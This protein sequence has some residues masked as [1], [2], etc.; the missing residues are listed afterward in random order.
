MATTLLLRSMKMTSIGNFIPTVCTALPGTSHS[1]SSG[2]SRFLR[3]RPRRRVRK[4]SA[5]LIFVASQ[6]F[7]SRFVTGILISERSQHLHDVDRDRREDDKEERRQ[8][9]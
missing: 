2:A 9:E 4:V 6:V 8:D 5:F 7:L 1:A 3:R